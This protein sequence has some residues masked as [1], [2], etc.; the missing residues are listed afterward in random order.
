M[1]LGVMRAGSTVVVSDADS[2]GELVARIERTR[3]ALSINGGLGYELSTENAAR[4]E[5]PW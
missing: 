5:Q 4:V 1:A 2:S 3:T